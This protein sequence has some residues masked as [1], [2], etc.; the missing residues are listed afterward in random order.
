MQAYGVLLDPHRLLCAILPWSLNVCCTPSLIISNPFFLR[1]CA[2]LICW[3]NMEKQGSL[4]RYWNISL[5]AI[6]FFLPGATEVVS[7][8]TADYGLTESYESTDRESILIP[9]QS[10]PLIDEKALLR[11]I[12]FRVILI[13]FIICM[14]AFLDQ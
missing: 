10:L 1:H 11:K 14:P 7:M 3:F 8:F 6:F 5:L 9:S 12:D 2:E 13:L 4:A